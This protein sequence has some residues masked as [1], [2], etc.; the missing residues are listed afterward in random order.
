M[1]N[2]PCPL[3]SSS[4]GLLLLLLVTPVCTLPSTEL[5]MQQ[6]LNT[7]RQKLV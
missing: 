4:E 3:K 7:Y 1:L 6:V 2:D 5:C